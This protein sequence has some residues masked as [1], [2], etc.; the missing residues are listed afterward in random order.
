MRTVPGRYGGAGFLEDATQF[1][2]IDLRVGMNDHEIKEVLRS[3]HSWS[4]AGIR[5]TSRGTRRDAEHTK[6]VG[7]HHD[8]PTPSIALSPCVSA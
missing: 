4:V 5:L 1:S 6:Q 2:S 3:S 8:C 7:D